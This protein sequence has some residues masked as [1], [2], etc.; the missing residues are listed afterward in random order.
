LANRV[1]FAGG[2]VLFFSIFFAG[3]KHLKSLEPI[4]VQMG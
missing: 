1:R 4:A 2:S 3:Q